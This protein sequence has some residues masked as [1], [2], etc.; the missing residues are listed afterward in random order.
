MARWYFKEKAPWS[1][2]FAAVLFMVVILL[3]IATTWGIP[4]RSPT[5]PDAVH[6]VPYPIQ[7]GR[8]LLCSALAGACD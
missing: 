4:E 6:S 5:V 3:D 7:R 8:N 1:V 2:T